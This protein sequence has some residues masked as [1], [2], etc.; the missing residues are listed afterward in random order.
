MKKDQQQSPALLDPIGY[1]ENR[2]FPFGFD[3][4][5]KLQQYLREQANKPNG[6]GIA[7]SQDINKN[8]DILASIH[9]YEHQAEMENSR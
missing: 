5:E 7:S 2:Y 4:P 8:P 6:K 1:Y 9:A 3:N